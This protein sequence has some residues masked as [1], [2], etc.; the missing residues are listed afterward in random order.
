MYLYTK[1]TSKKKACSPATP[2]STGITI[3]DPA[4]C[5]VNALGRD[6][7]S[8]ETLR[9]GRPGRIPGSVSVPQADL[10][11]PET[12]AFRPAREIAEIFDSAGARETGRVI[13]YCGGGIFATANA[14]WLTP[15]L[16]GEWTAQTARLC[17]STEP[18][19]G[20]GA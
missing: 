4:A 18:T 11:D 19:E 7:F 10:V 2:G 20:G 15:P 9:Y 13:T 12:G 16:A 1:K 3:D 6:V 5:L 8:G 17:R 14:F